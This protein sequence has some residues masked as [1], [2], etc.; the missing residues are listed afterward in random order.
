LRPGS[1]PGQ[2]T[3]WRMMQI[4]C[5]CIDGS[6]L[7]SANFTQLIDFILFS[8]NGMLLASLFSYPGLGMAGPKT[9]RS[10]NVLETELFLARKTYA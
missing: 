9:G 7:Y 10:R 6:A 4:S 8:L 5:H 1:T 3:V 2:I